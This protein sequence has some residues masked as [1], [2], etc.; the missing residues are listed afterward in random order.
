M[1]QIHGSTASFLVQQNT[2]TFCLHTTFLWPINGFKSRVDDICYIGALSSQLCKM[3]FVFVFFFFWTP[4]IV[5]SYSSYSYM[6][7]KF[8]FLIHVQCLS[9]DNVRFKKISNGQSF[10]NKFQ[11]PD[12]KIPQQNF[13]HWGGGDSHYPITLPGKPC[14]VL[15]F[16]MLL[17][18]PW[19][20]SFSVMYVC[21]LPFYNICL[22]TYFHI[23]ISVYVDEAKNILHAF[24]KHISFFGSA[25]LYLWFF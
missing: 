19:Q 10:L 22:L 8:W 2:G 11:P 4:G 16:F 14:C 5:V 23:K 25:S 18:R 17:Y 9:N 12:E 20:T 24:Y 1:Q 6:S 7:C 13:P 15:R 21:I 3:I